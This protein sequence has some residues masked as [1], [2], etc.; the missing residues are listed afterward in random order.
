MSDGKWTVTRKGARRTATFAGRVSASGELDAPPDASTVT[1]VS[2]RLARLGALAPKVF[3]WLAATPLPSLRTL[4]LVERSFSKREAAIAPD[5]TAIAAR[6][7]KLESLRILGQFRLKDVAH[8]KLERLMLEG[9]V[10]A[11]VFGKGAATLPALAHLTLAAD[12]DVH[13]V[14]WGF[15]VVEQILD[16]KRFPALAELD[17]SRLELDVEDVPVAEAL[18]RT[19]G[20]SKLEKLA[21]RLSSVDE[22]DAFVS[23]AKSFEHL[24]ELR[25]HGVRPG[26]AVARRLGARCVFPDGA[27]SADATDHLATLRQKTPPPGAKLDAALAALA[28]SLKGRRFTEH[29]DARATIVKLVTKGLASEAAAVCRLLAAASQGDVQKWIV[30][31]GVAKLSHA[32][33]WLEAFEV[34]HDCG[35]PSTRAENTQYGLDNML[36]NASLDPECAALYYLTWMETDPAQA[37]AYDPQ[38]VVAAAQRSGRSDLVRRVRA[39]K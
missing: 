1:D 18:A 11:A 8:P 16:A 15:A 5:W 29:D 14:A 17:V 22:L 13:G 2:L 6:T 10:C 38:W 21:L 30:Q 32:G 35:A 27:R 7:P 26:P 28:S 12:T 31:A 33:H 4:E 25:L 39:A 19:K 9:D 34:A 24:A 36:S 37:A 20:L 3:A 23:R